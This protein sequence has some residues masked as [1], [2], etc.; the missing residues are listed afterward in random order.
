MTRLPAVS[1]GQIRIGALLSEPMRV[2]TVLANGS[3]SLLCAEE[4]RM[5]KDRHDLFL[6][7]RRDR[8]RQHPATP[9]ADPRPGAP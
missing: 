5:A 2:E 4:R 9:G 1:P 6:P 8:L 7:L 3:A